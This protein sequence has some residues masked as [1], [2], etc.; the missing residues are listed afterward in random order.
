MPNLLR[1]TSLVLGGAIWSQW[2]HRL[3][4]RFALF[5]AIGFGCVMGAPSSAQQL[6]VGSFGTNSVKGYDATTGKYLSDFVPA[7][8][9]G[10]GGAHNLTLGPDGNLY[11]SGGN[12]P[13]GVFRYNGKTGAFMGLF[14]S[15]GN[16]NNAS[17]IVFRPDGYLYVVSSDSNQVA[18]YNAKTGVFVDNFA[19]FG[20]GDQP[21]DLAF[22]PNGNMLVGLGSS[23]S[24]NR[25]VQIN[26]QTGASLGDFI[27]RGSGGLDSPME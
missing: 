5:F 14:T 16:L 11:V 12:A 23:F 3:R 19:N 17:D 20:F 2:R 26:G 25:V 7:G 8:S 15:G 4:Y 1:S 21:I 27:P 24:S 13:Y 22:L 9:G 10:L 6:L 18:R